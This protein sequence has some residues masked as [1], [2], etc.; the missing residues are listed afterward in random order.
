VNAIWRALASLTEKER[1]VLALRFRHDSTIDDV[2]RALGVTLEKVRQ[3][4]ASWEFEGSLSQSFGFVPAGDIHERLDF[5]RHENGSGVF[6]DRE[7]G[8]E[9]YIGRAQ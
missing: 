6:L 4:E 2:G 3:L 8:K 7:T 5:L 1:L 9:V